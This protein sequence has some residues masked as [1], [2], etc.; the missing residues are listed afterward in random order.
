MG[1]LR[2]G[3]AQSRAWTYGQRPPVPELVREALGAS[4]IR[5]RRVTGR[6]RS[7]RRERCARFMRAAP[8]P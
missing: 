2:Q 1:C 4:G 3:R 6:R 8:G 7:R 5:S